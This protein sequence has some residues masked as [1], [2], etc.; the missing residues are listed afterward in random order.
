MGLFDAD[1]QD[2]PKARAEGLLSERVDG[3]LVIYDA[4]S[5][6]A[7]SLSPTAASVWDHCDGRSSQA[8]IAVRLE[9]PLELVEES[10]D[11][12]RAADLL[13]TNGITRRQAGRRFAAVGGAAVAAPLLYSVA[14]PSAAAAASALCCNGTINKGANGTDVPAGD[15]LW[16]IAVIQGNLP[17]GTVLHMNGSTITLSGGHP[18]VTLDVPDSQ[19]TVS[20]GAPADGSVTFDAPTAQHPNGLFIVSV[21]N[22]GQKT[23]L[24][25]LAYQLPAGGLTGSP[26]VSWNFPLGA[27]GVSFNYMWSVGAYS[28]FST[29]YNSLGLTVVAGGLQPGTP[30]NFEGDLVP[31]PDGGGGSNYTGSFSAT[32][33]CVCA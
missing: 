24:G 17:N 22:T 1:H 12:L 19:L 25:G 5:K 21:Q 31:G 13:A 11:E 10:V 4:A 2:R 26:N 16:F 3:D 23:F 28:A 6:T 9:L 14:I 33:S 20:A 15:F 7:H 8:D 29:N 18:S 30:T 27:T 32:N